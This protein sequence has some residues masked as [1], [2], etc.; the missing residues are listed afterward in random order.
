MSGRDQALAEAFRDKPDVV[1]PLPSWQLA[2]QDLAELRNR[3][4][5]AVVELA[6]RDSVAAA[7]AA[8]AEHGFSDLVPTCVYTGS[9]HG[10][11]ETVGQAWLRL[12]QRLPAQ[13]SL[14]PLLVYGSPLLW[15]AMNGRFAGEL[16]ARHG[17]PPFCV[18]CHLYLHALRLPLALALGGAPIVAGERESHDGRI[19]I[20]QLAVSLDAYRA[21]AQ[22]WAVDLLLPLRQVA[23][24][25]EVE[26]WLGRP[27]P[28]GGEQ[29][30][31]VLSGNYRAPDG[32][33]VASDCGLADYLNGF[34]LPLAKTWLT[35]LLAGRP[36]DPIQLATELLAGK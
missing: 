5:V 31:C 25:R 8:T 16:T 34:A 3:P 21:L 30:D 6:G 14:H 9:E 36:R 12:R 26:A 13:V 27:W 29:L 11:W 22:H 10:P 18:G 32:R 33:A 7:L 1:W 19:K 17:L 28:E 24:G 35:A 2:P 4:R 23:S 20:N 15:R